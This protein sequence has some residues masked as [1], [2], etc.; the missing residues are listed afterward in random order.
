MPDPILSETNILPCIRAAVPYSLY[1]LLTSLGFFSITPS[2]CTKTVTG[3]RNVEASSGDLGYK[4]RLKAE[5]P[6]SSTPDS[7][8]I[9]NL[10]VHDCIVMTQDDLIRWVFP[11]IGYLLAVFVQ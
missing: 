9:Q 2:P 5:A 4:S 3:P 7:D 6:A 1:R 10:P 8:S 11:P